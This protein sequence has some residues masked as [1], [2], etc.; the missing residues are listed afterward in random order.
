M[1]S[2]YK[3]I[4]R[5]DR[6]RWSGEAPEISPDQDLNVEVTVADSSP[7]GGEEERRGP[8]MA[9][10]LERIAAAGGPGIEDPVAWERQMREERSL[11]D[12]EG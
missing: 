7:A 5:G 2:T 6:L 1:A 11:P 10:A 3:A 12:R 8:R 4:L 9:A